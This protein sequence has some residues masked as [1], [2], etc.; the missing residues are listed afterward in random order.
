MI[1]SI[2]GFD[3][4]TD[5]EEA[6]LEVARGAL[7]AKP[8]R[9]LAASDRSRD[10]RSARSAVD[11]RTKRVQRPL[12]RQPDVY[13]E[14]LN[15]IFLMTARDYAPAAE[16]ARNVVARLE[17][18]PEVVEAAKANLLNPP[19]VWTEVGDRSRGVREV[20]PRRS[21][22]R[23]SSRRCPAR[24]RASRPR[25]R[26]PSAAYE[27]YKKFLQKEVLPRSNGRFAAGRELFEFLLKNDYF[28]DEGADELLA[29]GKKLFAETE[30]A[31]D[32]GRQAHR[33]EGEGLARGRRRSSRRITRR[34]TSC[35]T[36]TAT[37]S[38]RARAFL[39]AE[40]RVAFPPGDDLEVIDTPPF[41]RSTVTAAYDQPPPFDAQT[42]KGF[43]FVTPVDKTLS[44][45]K[46][47][48][49]LREN[50]SRRHR[51]HRR[52][53]RP[54]RATTS[55]SRSRAAIRRSFARRSTRR[56]SP[57]AGRSTP[58]SSWRSSATTTTR[59][60]SSS[61]SGRS[62]APRA[63][64]STSAS[65]SA[66]MTFEQAVKM[67]TDEVHLERQLALSEVKRYTRARRS[68]SRTS[69][70]AR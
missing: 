45:A 56:S 58:R 11:I 60:A 17:K 32:R 20:V 46:Q 18:I 51:R 66:D 14:P 53:T 27:D 44:K 38:P 1:A 65:T 26:S 52:S 48:E 41:L 40:G 33:P 5:R 55:S 9:E 29:M 69:S 64:S 19:R 21:S 37:R 36:R 24:R 31:D 13:V 15:A 47:E 35:S 7:Q 2:A 23:S 67:L 3:K 30:R 28:L 25:S 49:M 12:Q 68:R 50:D 63:S 61:S 39:V 8:K 4:A 70:A 34:P 16:R 10:A 57:R 6:M 54:T 22:V 59:S 62:F 43:F 42:T